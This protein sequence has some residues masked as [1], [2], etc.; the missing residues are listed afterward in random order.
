LI[1]L[2]QAALALSPYAESGLK[3]YQESLL[4]GNLVLCLPDIR[5]LSQDERTLTMAVGYLRSSLAGFNLRT[6]KMLPQI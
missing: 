6:E 2:G 3:Q 4:Q 1:L 5:A